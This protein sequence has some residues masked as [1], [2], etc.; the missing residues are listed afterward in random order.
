MPAD[1]SPFASGAHPNDGDDDCD[2]QQEEDD[3]HYLFSPT[4]VV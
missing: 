1:V 2:E 4:I 3:T